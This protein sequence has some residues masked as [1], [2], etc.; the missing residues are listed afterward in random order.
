MNLFLFDLSSDEGNGNEK[1]EAKWKKK[2]SKIKQKEANRS[3][4]MISLV[5]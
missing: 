1:L 3:D 4:K 2:L 5:S